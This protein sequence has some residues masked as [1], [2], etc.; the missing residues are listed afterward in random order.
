MGEMN[1]LP[2]EQAATTPENVETNVPASKNRAPNA[3][4][5][6]LPI[7]IGGIIAGVAAIAVTV[8]VVLGGAG[9]GNQGD[10]NNPTSNGH[11]HSYGEWTIVDDPTCLAAGIEERLCDCGAN[12]MRRV[13]ALG[14]T[15]VVHVPVLHPRRH[16]RAQAHQFLLRSCP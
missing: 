6:K 12:E 9:N 4:I 16:L 15:E 7:I 10:G 5:S 14:H 8:A 1:K 2:E 13:D 11:E 3:L